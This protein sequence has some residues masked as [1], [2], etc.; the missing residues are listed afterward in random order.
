MTTLV[1]AVAAIVLAKDKAGKPLAVVVAGHNGSGKSTMW[2]KTLSPMLRMPLVNADRM[3]LS[4]LPEPEP[5]PEGSR[6]EGAKDRLP[7]WASVLRDTDEGW[8][9]V[10]QK[11][12]EAFVVQAMAHRVPFAMETV[13]SH[14]R[15]LGNGRFES[16]IDRMRDMQRSG[17][18]VLLVFVGLANVQTSIARVQMRIGQGGHAVPQNKLIERFP[19]TQAAIAAAIPVA[20]A[21]ILTDNSRGPDQAFT[22]CRVQLGKQG[23]YDVRDNL[24]VVPPEIAAWLHKV[25]P[26]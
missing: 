1:E 15:P 25:S 14:W 24:P 2:T 19:R 7:E 5:R 3:M 8:M 13:F 16:K 10:A 18:F 23:L 17:Y 12:V 21:A 20:D 26:R 9:S 4:I 22:V 11:G 6:C